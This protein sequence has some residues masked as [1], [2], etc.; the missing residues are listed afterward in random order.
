MN[1]A[2]PQPAPN[3][4]ERPQTGNRL[5]TIRSNSSD[6]PPTPE[7]ARESEKALSQREE[8]EK[9]STSQIAHASDLLPPEYNRI[10]TNFS[11]SMGGA[12]GSFRSSTTGLQSLVSSMS[13]SVRSSF[14]FAKSTNSEIKKQGNEINDPSKLNRLEMRVYSWLLAYL[15]RAIQTE[16]ADWTETRR[17]AVGP[18]AGHDLYDERE[19]QN[20]ERAE[21]TST[22]Y[23]EYLDNVLSR[24]KK[25][26][27]RQHFIKDNRYLL[28]E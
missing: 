21:R 4:D 3:G 25:L 24:L 16:F 1:R 17:A 11:G 5:P 19:I 12:C 18:K 20:D 14:K 10:N 2:Q 22:L 8:E 26:L 7:L 28:C 6:Q 15:E 9:S 23:D 13:N 27:E